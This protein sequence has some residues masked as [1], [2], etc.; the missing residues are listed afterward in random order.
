MRA[1][2]VVIHD[3][4]PATLPAC[5]QMLELIAAIAPLPVTL[6]VVP[7]YHGA[8]A[9]PAFERW[10]DGRLAQGDELAL[11]GYT[12]RDEGRFRSWADY[13]RRCWYT[14]GEGEFAALDEAEAARRLAAGRHWFAAHDWP[15][16]G[17]VAPAW[18]MSQGTRRALIDQGFA[19][20][21]TLSRLIELPSQREVRSQS[22]VYSTRAAWRRASSLVWTKAVAFAERQ[23]PLL[24]LELHPPDLEHPAVR[25]SWLKL[26]ATA[27]SERQAMTVAEAVRKLPAGLWQ[28]GPS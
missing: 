25:A 27:Q 28:T 26:L 23:A 1:L 16:E 12:H 13:L 2:T 5:Q 21:A 6:L 7:H 4:A 17:F 9:D 18:L 19:Y 8:P 15:L 20:T 11:H 10:L 3:V 24:R 14:A 22:V